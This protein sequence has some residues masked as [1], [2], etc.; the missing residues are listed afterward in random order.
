MYTH[1]KLLNILFITDTLLAGFCKFHRA[2]KYEICFKYVLRWRDSFLIICRRYIAVSVAYV[3]IPNN[4]N[5]FFFFL[6]KVSWPLRR[7]FLFLVSENKSRPFFFFGWRLFRVVAN[8]A[9][10]AQISAP[11]DVAFKK[12]STD[13]YLLPRRFSTFVTPRVITT[14]AC[15]YLF[16]YF[17]QRLPARCFLSWFVILSVT[18]RGARCFSGPRSLG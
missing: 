4:S 7:F 16:F 9:F 15:V 3:R 13:D 12:R 14:R 5:T 10:G 17:Y 2:Q 18:R 8:D 11:V 6:L 1:F